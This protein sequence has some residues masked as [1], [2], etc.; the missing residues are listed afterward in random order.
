M[1]FQ[2]SIKWHAVTIQVNRQLSIL[3]EHAQKIARQP[4]P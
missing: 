2:E 3:P 4:D 1:K